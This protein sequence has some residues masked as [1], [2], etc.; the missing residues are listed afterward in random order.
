MYGKQLV[1]F[2]DSSTNNSVPAQFFFKKKKIE[3]L[4]NLI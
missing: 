3:F 2:I 1:A 4:I